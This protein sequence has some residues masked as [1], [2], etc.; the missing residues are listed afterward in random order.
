MKNQNISLYVLAIWSVTIPVLCAKKFDSPAAALS[1]IEIHLKKIVPNQNAIFSL[2]F[3]N[4]TEF[5]ITYIKDVIKYVEDNYKDLLNTVD[6]VIKKSLDSVVQY[7]KDLMLLIRNIQ[8]ANSSTL[9]N[10]PQQRNSLVRSLDDISRKLLGIINSVE[11]QKLKKGITT[12][13]KK[14]D[15]I[16]VIEGF[17]RIFHGLSIKALNQLP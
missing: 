8:R 7:S 6:P 9:Q 10:N 1:D 13:K 2:P 17:A 11:L 14:K 3:I 4:D 12:L 5:F 15:A 16:V